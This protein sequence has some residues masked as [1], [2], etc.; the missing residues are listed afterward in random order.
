MLTCLKTFTILFWKYVL[1]HFWG[2]QLPWGTEALFQQADVYFHKSV[3]IK[4]ALSSVRLALVGNRWLLVSKQMIDSLKTD[5]CFL[6]NMQALVLKQEGTCFR[7]VL[8]LK[9][10][11][12]MV[13][14]V[15]FVGKHGC[16][17]KIR[18]ACIEIGRDMLTGKDYFEMT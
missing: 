4:L 5:G 16:F 15:I 7:L 13:C 10:L 6:Q 12:L 2:R 17:S 14:V 3:W 1:S 11:S 9:G 8:V 18:R